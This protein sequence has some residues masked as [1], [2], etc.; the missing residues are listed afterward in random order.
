VENPI[1]ETQ[2]LRALDQEAMNR[3]FAVTDDLGMSRESLRV[4]LVRAGAG[5]VRKVRFGLY[6][7]TL[8][9]GDL[10][11]FLGRFV[12]LRDRADAEF[13]DHGAQRA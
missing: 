5:E 8:P 2:P 6:E 3:L 9:D 13:T 1:V 4:A 10:A 12:E 11:P 7:V